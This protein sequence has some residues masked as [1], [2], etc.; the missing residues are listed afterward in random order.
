MEFM[1]VG[2]LIVHKL[3]LYTRF[4]FDGYRDNGMGVHQKV[5]EHPPTKLLQRSRK[6]QFVSILIG[7]I[8]STCVLDLR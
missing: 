7:L 4:Q 2:T 8:R 1:I 5:H 6:V 3:R